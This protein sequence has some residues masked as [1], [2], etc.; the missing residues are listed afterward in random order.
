MDFLDRNNTPRW[1]VFSLDIGI[2]LV[3]LVLAYL[4]RF[5]FLNLPM[6]EEVPV[7]LVAF[8]VFI[9]VR[10]LTFYF[11][12]TYAGII[13][14]T[15]TQDAKRIFFVVG[16]GS[17]IFVALIPV[18][19]YLYDGYYFLPLSIIII[20]F[21]CTTFIMIASRIAVKLLWFERRRTGKQENENVII[22]GA[23]EMGLITKRTLDRDAGTQYKVVAFVDDNSSKAGKTIEGIKIYDSRSLDKVIEKHDPAQL[24]IGILRPDASNKRKLIDACLKHHIGVLNVPPVTDWIGGELSVR[25]IRKVRIEEL[26]GRAEIKL[27][28]G[29]IASQVNGKT[30]LVTGAAGS[31]GSEMVRQLLR[32]DTKQL[33]LLDQAES[34]LF[35]L[36]VELRSK[37]FG[38]RY[39]LVIGDIRNA[40]RMARLFD[41]LQPQIV[42]HAA[43]YK[44]VPMMEHNP[45]EALHTNV[46]G[47]LNLVELAV[48]HDIEAF[49]MISTDKAVN[50]TSVM[51][52]SKRIA[53]ICAQVQ[54]GRAKTHFITTRFGNVLGSNG[55]V[56]PLFRKQIEAGGPVTVTHE[57]VT[58]YFMTIPEACQLVL[59]AGAMG[60]GGEI[61]IFDM[62]DSIRII[63]LARKMIQ[64][65]G[66]EPDEDIEI[67]ITGLRPGEK[68]YE[69]LLTNEENT[70]PTHH[71]QILIARV[72][73]Y[74]RDE[75]M[76][77]ISELMK[78][79]G[80]QDNEAIVSKMKAIVP[81]Y[82][83]NNS[84]FTKLDDSKSVEK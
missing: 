56:I 63:D 75:V 51:G 61:F 14:Y 36:D 82:L 17:L 16:I 23:G 12:K 34:P 43:A 32:F 53:E 29:S 81:E 76:P 57:E 7:L 40:E 42:Y 30:V 58:R 78:L 1:I 4:I 74:D 19:Y 54:T 41:A 35:D 49:V 50:P 84:V 18:R 33:I 20:E 15:S 66:L 71:P 21:L 55:S 46:R 5:D 67:R 59:E 3:S 6:D 79:F 83:S 31:I 11:G 69:E 27:D 28:K 48:K 2:T 45:S 52:A 62:G 70:K 22:Y 39:E 38:D 72:Q 24:I 44:H 60:Q 47:T 37:E 13:R 10:G 65:S 26:L 73:E 80:S 68:L 8:P 25:Q 9:L 64:L 77:Q